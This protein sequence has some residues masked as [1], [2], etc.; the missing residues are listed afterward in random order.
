MLRLF[1]CVCIIAK[2]DVKQLR[3]LERWSVYVGGLIALHDGS[4]RSVHIKVIIIIIINNQPS[5]IVGG[6][7]E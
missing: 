5:S 4:C 1:F 6:N 7:S 2:R 3:A